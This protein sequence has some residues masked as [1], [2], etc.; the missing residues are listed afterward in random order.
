[1]SGSPLVKGTF[2]KKRNTVAFGTIITQ[3]IEPAMK[4]AKTRITAMDYICGGTAHT[5]TVMKALAKTKTTAAAVATGTALV[6]EAATF[7]NQTIAANDFIVVKHTDGTY[8]VYLVS[9]LTTL[10]VTIG[11]L[12]ADVASGSP[13]WIMGATGEAEHIPF[14]VTASVRNTYY[15]PIAGVVTSGYRSVYGGTVYQ[16]SGNDDPLLIHSNN[17]TA[18]GILEHVSGYYG[19][20]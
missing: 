3:V 12:S 18:T 16:R 4:G 2:H 14:L 7:L 10:T 8:G 19:S 5:V 11:A 9:A 17:A 20:P 1:M 13:V 15:D 6:L